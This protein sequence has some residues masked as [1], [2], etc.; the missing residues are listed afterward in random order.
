MPRLTRHAALLLFRRLPSSTLTPGEP[1]A[2]AVT[3]AIKPVRGNEYEKSLQHARFHF[4]VLF[5]EEV[6]SKI[7]TFFKLYFF[8]VN[9]YVFIKIRPCNP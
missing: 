9:N 5:S 6:L 2:K 4:V 8:Q 1:F 7:T 3:Q